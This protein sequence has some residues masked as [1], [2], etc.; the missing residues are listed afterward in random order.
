[1]AR[2]SC[3]QHAFG[4]RTFL[5]DSVYFFA[6]ISSI[7]NFWEEVQCYFFLVNDGVHLI[8]IL[9]RTICRHVECR[10]ILLRS[11]L[12]NVPIQG[13]KLSRSLPKNFKRYVRSFICKCGLLRM[14]WIGHV[15]K[16]YVSNLEICQY[17]NVSFTKK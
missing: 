17:L 8:S 7:S 13:K 15:L 14:T 1:M 6:W 3:S 11:T 4:G 5:L 16:D 9:F 2:P 10:N 12:W